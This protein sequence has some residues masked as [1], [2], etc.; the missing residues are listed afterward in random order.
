[1]AYN[2]YNLGLS[3]EEIKRRLL[4]LEGLQ[5]VAS[6][7]QVQELINKYIHTDANTNIIYIDSGTI[8]E[9]KQE[10]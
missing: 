7:Q 9:L 1:M 4:L 5:T 8:A 10:Q 3:G 2:L 6:I